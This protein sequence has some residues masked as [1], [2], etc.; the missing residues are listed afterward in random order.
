MGIRRVLVQASHHTIVKAYES[1]LDA[2]YMLSYERGDAGPLAAF[3]EQWRKVAAYYIEEA[4]KAEPD[5]KN[6][7]NRECPF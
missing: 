3:V 7:E 5:R 4:E 1:A 2:A 6:Q